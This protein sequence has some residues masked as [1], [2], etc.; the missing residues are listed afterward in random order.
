MSGN[1]TLEQIK[2]QVNQL[3]WHDQLRLVSYISDQLSNIAFAKDEDA[4][5][6]LQKQ[7]EKEAVRIL[8]R[9]KAVGRLWEGKFDVVEEIRQMRE[10]RDEQIWPSK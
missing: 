9:C 1:I 10:E 3:S 7:R 4:D 8:E 2:K 6:L 5:D